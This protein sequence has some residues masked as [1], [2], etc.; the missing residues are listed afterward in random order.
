MQQASGNP[1]PYPAS[2]A[3]LRRLRRRIELGEQP[4]GSGGPSGNVTIAYR[5]IPGKSPGLMFLTGY[6]SSMAGAKA[7]ALEAYCRGSGRAY[8]RFDYQ[9]HGETGGDFESC[10]LST[11]IG[12]ALAIL[13]EATQGPQILVG[14][15]MGGWIIVRL[16]LLRPERVAGLIGIATAADFTETLMWDAFDTE[17]RMKI[18]SGTPWRGPSAEGDSETVVTRALIEDGRRHLVLK[19]RIAIAQPV[20]LL[21]GTADTAVPWKLSQ[22]L[23]DRLESEDATLILIKG[24]GHRLSK[25]HELGHIVRA[26]DELVRQ[27]EA[28]A[29]SAST[30]ASPSR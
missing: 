25:P 19:D 27:V 5:R 18:L 24:G 21:H 15:S 16:A 8:V 30:A 4:L 11:W 17:W 13:D 10:V 26:A 9:G 12:D 2:A 22:Q 14:S 29:S 28:G 1:T 20:R 23:L 7:L 6:R 3:P